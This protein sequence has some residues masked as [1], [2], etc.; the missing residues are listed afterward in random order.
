VVTVHDMLYLTQPQH[1][2]DKL[3]SLYARVFI[4]GAVRQADMICTGSTYSKNEIVLAYG[5][6]ADRIRVTHYGVSAR[7][8]LQPDERLALVRERYGLERPYFLFVG[9]WDHPRKNLPRL[10][11]AF[12]LFCEGRDDHYE[13]VLAGPEGSSS[14]EVRELMRES[15]IGKRIRTLGF[16]PD[17]DMPS[18]YAAAEVFAFPSLGE[19]F[20]IPVIEAMACGTPVIVSQATCLPE[21]AGDAAVLFDPEDPADIAR[22]MRLILRPQIHEEMRQKGLR[23]AQMFTWENTARE[24]LNAYLDALDRRA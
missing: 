2:K 4:K 5:V 15:E 16:V 18:I 6:S 9:G 22:A 13:L 21:V 10:I 3:F 12:L 24:T 8:A 19:G 17:E 14:G 7:Y 11:R 20:G 23:R 1:Y